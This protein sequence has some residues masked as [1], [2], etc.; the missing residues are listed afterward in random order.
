MKMKKI[1]PALLLV[2]SSVFASESMNIKCVAE[3]RCPANASCAS[4]TLKIKIENNEV[5]E[6]ISSA[7][8]FSDV[9]VGNYKKNDSR[10][11]MVGRD[12]LGDPFSA[13]I[14]LDLL[15]E[16]N[17]TEYKTVGR[18]NLFRLIPK[19]LNCIQLE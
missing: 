6:V 14:Q 1:I 3:V 12:A 19:N 17:K 5:A 2:S 10:I 7:H 8:P 15:E 16:V 11:K 9:G 4:R 18:Y 13:V